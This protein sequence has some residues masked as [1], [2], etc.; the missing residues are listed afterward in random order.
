M[1]LL[2]SG[3]D[4]FTLNEALVDLRAGL[5]LAEHDVTRMGPQVS[6]QELLAV[7]QTPAFFSPARLIVVEGLLERFNTRSGREKPAARKGGKKEQALGAW[8][9]LLAQLGS[10][11]ESVHLV[12]VDAS[13]QE[14]NPMLRE[15]RPQAEERRFQ[16]PDR[17][18]NEWA[19]DWVRERAQRM[20]LTFAGAAARVLIDLVEP[21]LWALNSELV[22]LAVYGNG[23]PVGVEAV[24]ALV[25]RSREGNIFAVVDAI[26]EGRAGKAVQ[27]LAALDLRNFGPEYPLFML[28]SQYRRLA[29]ARSL[30]DSGADTDEVGRVLGI[31]SRFPLEKA[32]QQAK[33]YNMAQLQ[34]VYECIAE[35]DGSFKRGI[36]EAD[37]ALDLLVYQLAEISRS[38]PA[39]APRLSLPLG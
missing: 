16:L 28:L 19:G 29:Q 2:F 34:A 5:Q 10:M 13:V 37:T 24:Q 27:L 31:R 35:A 39:R 9:P 32:V 23:E 36:M 30:L 3:N 21:N 18:W 25:G 33:R 1:I 8:E 38:K 12:F 11:P 22:K 7:C 26:V 4:S 17:G 20:G 14:S 6:P 15:L